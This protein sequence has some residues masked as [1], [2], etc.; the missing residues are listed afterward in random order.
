M[1]DLQNN[2]FDFIEDYISGE[3]TPEEEANF[4]IRLNT[5]SS[6]AEH[7]KIRLKLGTL[8]IDS[9]EY[10]RTKEIVKSQRF[11]IATRKKRQ[12]FYFVTASAVCIAGMVFL[13][14]FN[15][16]HEHNIKAINLREDT[17]KEYTPRLN[18]PEHYGNLYST[19]ITYSKKDTLFIEW[20]DSFIQNQKVSIINIP[21]STII[22]IYHFH[23]KQRLQIPLTE[24]KTGLYFWNFENNS[25]SGK[26]I[27]KETEEE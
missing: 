26:F 3:L 6:F 24:F 1:T 2:D 22:A 10:E 16:K 21:D 23:N 15:K 25:A 13:L 20:N 9:D 12:R 4:V 11:H 5:D 14:N 19:P 8:W 27:I 7:Y 17:T 18:K